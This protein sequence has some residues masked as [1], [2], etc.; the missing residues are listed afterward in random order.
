MLKSTLFFAILLFT[1]SSCS[2]D[3]FADP[4]KGDNYSGGL[5]YQ[6]IIGEEPITAT[7][8]NIDVDEL[9]GDRIE[10]KLGGTLG[11]MI[12]T[13]DE[14]GSIDMNPYQGVMTDGTILDLPNGN[15]EFS[16][17]PLM[18]HPTATEVKTIIVFFQDDDET[19]YSTLTLAEV[20]E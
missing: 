12:G 3:S 19:I 2:N 8:E 1:V 15:G 16:I 10:I 13:V 4:V 14:S 6:T 18:G 11:S 17:E 7:F 20:I 5:V 9:G